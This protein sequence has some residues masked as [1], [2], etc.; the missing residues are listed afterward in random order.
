M[1]KSLYATMMLILMGIFFAGSLQ[2]TPF[3]FDNITNNNATNAAIGESQ[4][5]LD[6]SGSGSNVVF[7][8]HNNGPQACSIT[9]V[10][11]DY[12]QLSGATASIDAADSSS[13]VSFSPGATPPNLPGAQNWF[14]VSY[15]AD[16]NS[17]VM[18]NGV[19]PYEYLVID[20]NFTNG[21]TLNDIIA[22]LNSNTMITGI[23]VQG[24]SNGGS[25]SFVTTPPAPV[26]EPST[27]ILIGTGLIGLARLRKRIW[28]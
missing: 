18:R 25:E 22:A 19:N 3:T 2:A 6:V 12:A 28:K 1:K 16:S 15:S 11:F 9:D 10:Y 8:F 24:F 7:T 5:W 17:P 26:P 21:I 13:G 14:E 20:F 4:L 27:M 23:H